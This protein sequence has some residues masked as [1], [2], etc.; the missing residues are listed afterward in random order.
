MSDDKPFSQACENNKDPILSILKQYLE[1]DAISSANN[2]LLEIG[3]GTGQHA[4]HMSTNLPHILWQPTDL[5]EN[6]A[7]IE[8]WQQ[9]ANRP[10][11]LSPLEFNVARQDQ[12]PPQSNHL[13]TANTLH[14][15][16][17]QMV[18]RLFDVIPKLVKPQGFTFF[19]GPFKYNNEFT[20]PS[21]ANFDIWLKQRAEHQGI[22]DIEAVCSLA[23]QA[24]L[25]QLADIAM[26]ANNQ[27]LVFQMG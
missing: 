16:S 2:T 12:L 24:N 20:T 8:L 3:S 5:P 19:Y 23:K 10:N 22:R 9:Q 15:M 26:P 14:I 7:G 21:N 18:E 13:F 11:L 1:S 27:L 25:T 6:L 4:V 17:W